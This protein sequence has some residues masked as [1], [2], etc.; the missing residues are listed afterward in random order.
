MKQQ[1]ANSKQQTANSK[2]QTANSKR[3]VI[4]SL[5]V[6]VLFFI[7]FCSL[8]YYK[9]N[10]IVNIATKFYNTLFLEAKIEE[11]GINF[12]EFDQTKYQT[13]IQFINNGNYHGKIKI[14]ILGNSL[15]LIPSWNGGAGLTASDK[16]HDYVHILLNRISNEKKL[17][18]EYIVLNIADFE[19]GFKQFDYTRLE[20]VR[21]FD[22]EIIIFQIGENVSTDDFTTN[23]EIFIK[24]YV[25]LIKYC[26]G[27]NIIVCLP[28]WPVKEKLKL[29]T[30]V[31]LES[32]SYLVDLS[33]LGSGIDPLNFARSEKKYDNAGVG[34]HPGDYGMNNI[35]KILYVIMN[36]IIE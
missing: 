31:A 32:G 18:I 20:I 30:E 3:I 16:D 17:N 14:A 27:E 8:A 21:N 5:L 1:T 36:R 7:T 6:N 19:R 10:S 12:G 23:G 25:N 35:A 33:H 2:Q 24:N 11:V 34:A 26:D 9:R 29:I 22:P 28:F 15:T 13:E 4:V